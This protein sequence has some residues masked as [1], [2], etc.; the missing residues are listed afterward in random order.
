MCTMHVGRRHSAMPNLVRRWRLPRRFGSWGRWIKADSDADS[1][2]NGGTAVTYRAVG[3]ISSGLI[4]CCWK[5]RKAT[6]TCSSSG[7]ITDTSF[8]RVNPNKLPS[9]TLD[10]HCSTRTSDGVD[11][12]TLCSLWLFAFEYRLEERRYGRILWAES[13][14]VN[15]ER[16]TV[17]RIISQRATRLVLS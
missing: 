7:R 15:T 12:S 8:S 14:S 4:A 11:A 1:D 9:W 3:S 16:T 6:E 13:V 10:A 2:T 17:T 5:E